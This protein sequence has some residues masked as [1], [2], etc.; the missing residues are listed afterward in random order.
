MNTPLSTN[1]SHLPEAFHL[2]VGR[3]PKAPVDSLLLALAPLQLRNFRKVRS[4]SD[5]LCIDL[6]QLAE[7]DQLIIHRLYESLSELLYALANTSTSD[8]GKWA[9]HRSLERAA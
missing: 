8:A 5:Q 4:C 6:Q 9:G 3:D 2:R 1:K 7:H